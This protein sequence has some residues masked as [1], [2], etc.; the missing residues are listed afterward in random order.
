M[1][2]ILNLSMGELDEICFWV[3]DCKRAAIEKG[4]TSATDVQ[5]L[6]RCLE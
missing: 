4:A 3:V 6:S 5:K 1:K 2:S